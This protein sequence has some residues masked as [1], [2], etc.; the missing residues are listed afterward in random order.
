MFFLLS[1]VY[2]EVGKDVRRILRPYFVTADDKPKNPGKFFYDVATIVTTLWFLNYA[3]TS[4]LYLSYERGMTLY[5]NLYF[6]GHIVAVVALVLFRFVFVQK[7]AP[8]P[9][10]KKTE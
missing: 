3:G 7:R 9:A 6:G 2:T 8:R 1:A 10:T 5:T 4:F